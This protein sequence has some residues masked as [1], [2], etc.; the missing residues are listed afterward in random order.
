MRES[1]EIALAF[2]A[3]SKYTDNYQSGSG[4]KRRGRNTMIQS[5]PV[6]RR[7]RTSTPALIAVVEVIAQGIGRAEHPR[8][9]A[10]VELGEL[11]GAWARHRLIGT[12]TQLGKDGAEEVDCVVAT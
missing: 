3:G 8:G 5:Q 4:R 1:G 11:D 7:L 10:A 2:S 6:T 12:R 9:D